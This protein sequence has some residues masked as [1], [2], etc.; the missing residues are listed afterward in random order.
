MVLLDMLVESGDRSIDALSAIML[1]V[2]RKVSSEHDEDRI[3]ASKGLRKALSEK[4]LKECK[5]LAPEVS[6]KD[7]GLA[8][9]QLAEY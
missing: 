8:A 1:C 7:W 2:S 6:N 4:I 5:S 9:S 3:N